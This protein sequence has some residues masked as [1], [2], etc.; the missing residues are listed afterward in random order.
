[1]SSE[2]VMSVCFHSLVWFPIGHQWQQ[3]VAGT[4]RYSKLMCQIPN[5]AIARTYNLSTQMPYNQRTKEKNDLELIRYLISNQTGHKSIQEN[6][7]RIRSLFATW[8]EHSACLF[9][10]IFPISPAR[11]RR[12]VALLL[13]ISVRACCRPALGGCAVFKRRAWTVG[14]Q[15]CAILGIV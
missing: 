5:H 13:S 8:E 6:R 2:Y 15:S 7:L 10:C 12:I 4:S 11:R 14:T 1:M 9:Q 3:L